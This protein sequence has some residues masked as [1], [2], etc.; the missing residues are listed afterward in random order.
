M[1]IQGVSKQRSNNEGGGLLGQNKKKIPVNI[2][3]KMLRLPGSHHFV[4]FNKLKRFVGFDR[5]FAYTFLVGSQY[6]KKKLS[7]QFFDQCQNCGQNKF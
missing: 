7:I 3:P 4:I 6:L 5:N 2:C 1:H